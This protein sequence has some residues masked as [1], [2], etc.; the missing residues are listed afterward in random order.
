MIML[1]R[2]VVPNNSMYESIRLPATTVNFMKPPPG[3]VTHL[4]AHNYI[5]MKQNKDQ[6]KTHACAV[7]G[8]RQHIY[9]MCA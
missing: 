7:L 4:C 5:S 9:I 3:G 2:Y 6:N 1:I 8:A